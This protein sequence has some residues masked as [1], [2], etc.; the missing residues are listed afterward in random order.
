[1][2]VKITEEQKQYAKENSDKDIAFKKQQGFF[3]WKSYKNP[4]ENT[5][6]G[7]LSEVCFADILYLPRP[8]VKDRAKT[9]IDFVFNNK[10]IDLKA[11]NCMNEHVRLLVRQDY[12]CNEIDLFVL[13]RIKN[14]YFEILGYIEKEELYKTGRKESVGYANNYVLW[15]YELKQFDKIYMV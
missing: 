8:I 3:N 12:P 14:D 1:M 15:D 5:Y 7:W 9:K 11:T 10:R 2:K 13:A 4:E 6:I